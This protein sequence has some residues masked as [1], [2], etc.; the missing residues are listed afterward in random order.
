M[1]T[2]SLPTIAE[3]GRDVPRALLLGLIWLYQHTLGPALPRS[4]RYLPTCSQYGFEAIARYGAARGSW[5][6]LK[7]LARCQPFGGHGYDPVP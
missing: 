7:R 3:R 6:T 5:L 2:Q 1:A 4:C